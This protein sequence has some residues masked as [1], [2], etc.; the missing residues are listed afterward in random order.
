MD[1]RLVDDGTLDTVL[2]C[3]ECG[4]QERFT[5]AAYDGPFDYDQFVEWARGEAEQYHECTPPMGENTS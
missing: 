5:F 3:E 4:G 1:F 2:E